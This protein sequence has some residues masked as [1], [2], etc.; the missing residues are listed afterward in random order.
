MASGGSGIRR[1]GEKV[2]ERT[3]GG[4]IEETKRKTKG[5]GLIEESVM[6][7][8]FF[9]SQTSSP[10]LCL[11]VATCLCLSVDIAETEA[12]YVTQM[13]EMCG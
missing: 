10:L 13:K 9:L 3:R 7:H 2:R 5:C 4:W 6:H 11:F 8:V 12:C 1:E